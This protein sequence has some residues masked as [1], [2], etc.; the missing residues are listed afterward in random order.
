MLRCLGNKSPLQSTLRA[1]CV[2][3][4]TFGTAF[5]LFCRQ[6]SQLPLILMGSNVLLRVFKKQVSPGIHS[7]ELKKVISD[8][9]QITRSLNRGGLNE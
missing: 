7:N 6:W 4:H 2:I 8:Q 1:D 9:G 5:A 3:S